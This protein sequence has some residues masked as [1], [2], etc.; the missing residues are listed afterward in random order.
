MI[1]DVIFKLHVV[2]NIY[3][4]IMF[5]KSTREYTYLNVKSD[6]RYNWDVIHALR[7]KHN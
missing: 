6:V 2:T 7:I 5:L 4:A 3:K 1:A